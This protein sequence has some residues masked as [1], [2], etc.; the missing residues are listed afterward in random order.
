MFLGP[1]ATVSE[2]ER[3]RGLR[4]LVTDAMFASTTAALNGGVVLAAYALWL[5]ASNAVI[6]LLAALPFLSQL[7]QAPAVALVER[8]QARR[9]IC[10]VA[11]FLAR[12]LLPLIGLLAFLPDRKL[13]LGLLV[14][15][16][17]AH[18]GLN[19]V[20]TCAWNSWLRDL[21]PPERL[22]RFFARRTANV[23]AFTLF[24]TLAAGLTVDRASEY[25]RTAEAFVF[26]GV[27]M[28]AFATSL[29]SSWLI[30]RAPE[31]RMAPPVSAASLLE[32]LRRPFRDVNFRRLIV[33]LSS[34]QF[35]VNLATPFITVWLLGQL[36][37]SMGFVVSLSV[38]SQAANLAVL[39]GWGRLS[40]RFANKSVLGV[41]APLLIA[42]IAGLVL[43][44]QI[45]DQRLAAAYLLVLHVLMGAATAGVGLATGAIALKLAPSGQATP[46]VA[47]SAL[48]SSLAAG[49]APVIGGLGADFFAV[50][51]LTLDVRWS[52]PEG[53]RSLLAFQLAHWDFFFLIAALVG[54]YAL[55]RLTLVR[56]EGEIEQ[57]E[58]ARQI[59]LGARRTVRNLSPVAGLRV[60]AAFPAGAL[61]ELRRRG[62]NSRPSTGSG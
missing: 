5:G 41:A 18:A 57:G 45:Q 11:A 24:A 37:F 48:T 61:I 54:L 38:V 39:G 34:W 44:S 17:A 6:G 15:L 33:F 1:Q 4:S 50:R 56:E 36:G 22:G 60:A 20:S 46:Y 30:A 53:V 29:A 10:V 27:F 25:G 43:A 58:M 62:R 52:D 49:I 59:L 2:A 21:A 55:H 26:A 9:M 8:L 28:T 23:T 12:L 35:A 47:A 13:A 3:E 51:R 40:D 31:P 19:A 32:V 7:L 42:C 14:G 16:Q